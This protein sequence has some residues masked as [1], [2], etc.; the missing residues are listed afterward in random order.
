MPREDRQN[1]MAAQFENERLP[2]A[3][4]E[5]WFVRV[6]PG[7]YRCRVIQLYDPESADSRQVFEQQSPHFILEILPAVEITAPWASVPWLRL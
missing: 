5:Q 4:E 1:A 2:Q 6:R 3:H 7:S